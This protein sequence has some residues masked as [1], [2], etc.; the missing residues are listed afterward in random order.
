[1]T[2][3][4]A[5]ESRLKQALIEVGV[6]ESKVTFAVKPFI[7]STGAF[8]GCYWLELCAKNLPD[9]ATYKA[10]IELGDKL[11]QASGFIPG[12]MDRNSSVF[13]NYIPAIGYNNF[14]P[15]ED[16]IAQF[17][18]FLNQEVTVESGMK[19][20]SSTVSGTWLNRTQSF[21]NVEAQGFRK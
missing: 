12:S 11:N 15:Y 8:N 18:A 5:L 3:Q 17:D 9:E 1:M 6:E 10:L 21:G 13:G 4:Q 2:E 16:W 7:D 19:G 14:K 20:Y